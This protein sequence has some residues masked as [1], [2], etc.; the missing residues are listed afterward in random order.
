MVMKGIG[1]ECVRTACLSQCIE[2]DCVLT[3]KT[4][5]IY[6]NLDEIIAEKKKKKAII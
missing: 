5:Y 3:P 2:V 1:N 4:K 6:I